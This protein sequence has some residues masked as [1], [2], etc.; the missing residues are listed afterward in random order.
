MIS[1]S[2]VGSPPDSHNNASGSRGANETMATAAAIAIDMTEEWMSLLINSF[3]SLNCTVFI[4]GQFADLEASQ[5]R[6]AA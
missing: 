4:I 5:P 1:A 3:D 2:T 6:L